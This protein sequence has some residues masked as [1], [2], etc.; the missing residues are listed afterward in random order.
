M[1]AYFSVDFQYSMSEI[2]AGQITKFCKML[3]KNGAEF[4]KGYW[5]ASGDSY[6]EILRNDRKVLKAELTGKIPAEDLAV[7]QPV[8]SLGEFENIRVMPLVHREER[9]LS[10]TLLVPEDDLVCYEDDSDR[11]KRLTERM[12][13][14][15]ELAKKVWEKCP[16][17]CVQTAWELSVPCT[18]AREILAGEAP[19]AE[20]FAIVGEALVR[21]AW[22]G[23]RTSFGK[24][25]VLL[26]REEHWNYS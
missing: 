4:V 7:K 15:K 23:T 5:K 18:D 25:A 2:G 11:A 24:K 6:A 22:E 3:V 9:V 1:P 16:G 12:N 20:P 21:D 8:F 26:E 14:L 17:I 10:M 13:C 19:H